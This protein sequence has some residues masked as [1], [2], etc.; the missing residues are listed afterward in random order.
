MIHGLEYM[1][2]IEMI[3]DLISDTVSKASEAN[4]LD[5]GSSIIAMGICNRLGIH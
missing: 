2:L 1:G 4:R 3:A 5:G